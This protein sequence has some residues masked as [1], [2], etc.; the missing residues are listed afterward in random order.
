LVDVTAVGVRG[1]AFTSGMGMTVG[2]VAFGA[3]PLAFSRFL[4]GCLFF[5]RAAC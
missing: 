4:L 3:F 2:R 1:I 5:Q